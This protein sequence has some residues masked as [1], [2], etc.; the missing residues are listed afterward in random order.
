MN[1]IPVGTVSH[2]TLRNEDLIP[3]FFDALESYV[4]DKA[5]EI[6][7]DKDYYYILEFGHYDTETAYYLLE[8]LIDCLNDIA[9]E[10]YYFGAHIGDGSDFGFWPIEFLD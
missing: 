3:D 9:P 5:Q 1:K 6:K 7:S 4:P 10:G 2:G 8:D